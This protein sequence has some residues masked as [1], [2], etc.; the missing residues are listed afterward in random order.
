MKEQFSLIRYIINNIQVAGWKLEEHFYNVL[1]TLIFPVVTS[2]SQLNILYFAFHD[3]LKKRK[4]NFKEF[5]IM[6]SLFSQAKQSHLVKSLPCQ[7]MSKTN[8]AEL[9]NSAI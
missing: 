5:E 4:L 6:R 8:F 1:H 9:G 7:W 3:A 2:C